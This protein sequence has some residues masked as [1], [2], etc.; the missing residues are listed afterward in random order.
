MVV[1]IP[2]DVYRRSRAVMARWLEDYAERL[3]KTSLGK[4][5]MKLERCHHLIRILSRRLLSC[6]LNF[7][8]L[9]GTLLIMKTLVDDGQ[10]LA[11]NLVHMCDL[12]THNLFGE[13]LC[14]LKW[15][16]SNSNDNRAI[17]SDL[18][19]N[20]DDVLNRTSQHLLH[21]Y[22][23]WQSERELTHALWNVSWAIGLYEHDGCTEKVLAHLKQFNP[24]SSC[25]PSCA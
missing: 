22:M 24:S 12:P 17:P 19:P 3:Y 13:L 21:C 4:P 8:T 10:K 5:N 18:K 23:E 7:H 11:P 20:L 2:E 6:N 15:V 1:N 9:S 16:T 25:S 14:L